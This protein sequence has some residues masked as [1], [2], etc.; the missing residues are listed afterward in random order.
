MAILSPEER[1]HRAFLL[2]LAQALRLPPGTSFQIEALK[3]PLNGEAEEF[4]SSGGTEDDWCQLQRNLI[5]RVREVVFNM[6]A[7][8]RRSA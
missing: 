6:D 2:E 1:A 7:L 5:E 4:V 8:T 3:T